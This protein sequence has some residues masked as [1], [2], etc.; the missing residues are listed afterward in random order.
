MRLLRVI[1]QNLRMNPIPHKTK[2]PGRTGVFLYTDCIIYIVFHKICKSFVK[3]H[4]LV[5][6]SAEMC[7][8]KVISTESHGHIFTS[9]CPKQRG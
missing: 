7:Y 8:N 5:A 9:R 2:A 3:A 1:R 6:I 4:S